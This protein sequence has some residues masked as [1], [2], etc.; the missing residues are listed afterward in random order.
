MHKAIVLLVFASAFIFV[1]TANVNA[2]FN[3]VSVEQLNLDTLNSEQ[4]A[5]NIHISESGRLEYTE[6][7]GAY[8][9]RP[10]RNAPARTIPTGSR[11]ISTS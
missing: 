7:R 5:A 10:V 11:P 9:R 2:Q 1:G 4:T 8:K 6:S 3:L